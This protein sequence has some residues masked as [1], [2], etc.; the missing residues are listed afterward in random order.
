MRKRVFLFTAVLIL[1]FLFV[2]HPEEGVFSPNSNFF[3]ESMIQRE[4][5]GTQA[6]RALEVISKFSIDIEDMKKETIKV[7]ASAYYGPIEGQRNYKTG[8]FEGDVRL[9]G[10]GVT[11]TEKQ[12]QVGY[13]AADWDILPEGTKVQIPGYGKAV[14]EDI[15]GAI[16]GYKIDLF[17]GYGDQGLE[18]ALQWGVRTVEIEIIEKGESGE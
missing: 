6:A 7:R 8:S 16:E 1:S 5:A 13:I 15:G 4:I 9:N 18:K 2:R 17:M 10:D 11:K 14:V 12:A 3:I